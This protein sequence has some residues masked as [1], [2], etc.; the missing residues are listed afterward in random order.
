[1]YTGLI[2]ALSLDV[3]DITETGIGPP[4]SKIAYINGFTL[5]QSTQTFEVSRVGQVTKKG[6]TGL[7]TWSAGATGVASFAKSG[8]ALLYD[9]MKKRRKVKLYLFLDAEKGIYFYGT[10]Y[11]ESMNVDLSA[12]GVA[13]IAINIIGTEEL[14]LV[15]PTA[16]V[17]TVVEEM[18]FKFSID[19]ENG[20]LVVETDDIKRF[21]AKA[22]ADGR[23]V[24]D[25]TT[26]GGFL[27][28][29]LSRTDE[30]P[31]MFF[32][33]KINEEGELLIKTDSLNDYEFD[34]SDD[35]YLS[36]RISRVN[37]QMKSFKESGA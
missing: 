8:Q 10:G 31:E 27:R 30:Q 26:D 34:F 9:A 20:E 17:P 2:G 35:G 3:L 14:T 4:D 29:N 24:V 36:V 5:D 19:E 28:I 7:Q 12:D 18:F 32:K 13:N 25:K 23:Y 21:N 16:P 22:G 15:D 37:A 11:I 6:Y 1:M 33:F